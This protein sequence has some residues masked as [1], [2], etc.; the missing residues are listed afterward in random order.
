M[1]TPTLLAAAFAVA[2]PA[3]VFAQSAI[4]VHDPYARSSGMSAVSGAAFMVLHN[5][6]DVDDRLVS[7]SSPVAERVELHTHIETEDGVMRMV[8]VEEGFVLPAGG[9]RLLARGG[10]HVMFLGITTPFEDGATVPLTLTFEKAGDVA[11]AV[12][13]D[14]ARMPGAHGGHGSHGGHG[15]PGMKMGN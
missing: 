14:L 5:H 11:V 9:E 4:E 3:T 1:K 12:P 8:E 7:V 10:D 6:G 15:G 13:V 2:L